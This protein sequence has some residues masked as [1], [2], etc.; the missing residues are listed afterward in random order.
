MCQFRYAVALAALLT[1]PAAAQTNW[2][3][4]STANGKIPLPPNSNQQTASLVAD[5]TGDGV[6]DFVMANRTTTPSLVFYTKTPNRAWQRYII[7]DQKTTIEAGGAATDMDADGDTDLIFAGDWQSNN[8]W[9]WENPGTAALK[10]TTPWKRHTIKAFGAKQ[11][12]DQIVGDFKRTGRPQVVSWNQGSKTLFIADVP[13][14]PKTG[15]WKLDTLFSG[16]AGEANSWYAEGLAAADIDG[17]GWLDLLGGNYWFRYVGKGKFKPVKIA[18]EGGRIG[19]GKFRPGRVQQVVISPGDGKGKLMY[20]EWTGQEGQ[21]S[22][23]NAALW[24]GRDLLGRTMIHGH[25]MEV[26]DLN[27]DG[28]LDFLTAEMAKWSEKETKPDNPAAEALIYYGDGR[29]NF[30]KEVFKTGWGFHEARVAD[31]DGDGDMDILSKPY[32]WETPRL[33]VW[34][35]NGS[36]KRVDLSKT[37]QRIGLELYSFRNELPKDVPGTLAKIKAMGI[38]EVE[39]AGYYDLTPEQFRAELDKAGLKATGALLGFDRF[40]T[41]VDGIIREAKILGIKAVGCAWIPHVRLFT[42]ADAEKGA[43]VF[44]AAGEKLRANGIRFYYHAHGYEF[45]PMMG[46]DGKPTGTLFDHMATLMKPGVAD[47]QIDVYWALHG[48]ERPEQLIRRYPNRIVGLHLKDMAWGQENGIYT[49][50][51]PIANDCIHGKG[52]QNF[53]AILAA[54]QQAGIQ[55]LYIEDENLNAINQVP[56]S[57]TYLRGLK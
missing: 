6:S 41:D 40:Q 4:E 16:S 43:A 46:A 34:L 19:V 45:R 33:D 37:Q 3:Y 25:T 57:L 5:L 47:F 39:V 7:D 30:R 22:V 42:K 26:A 12:H 27:N 50:G 53:K 38:N 51:A 32:N 8:I 2:V 18:E 15:P 48:G 54:A 55:H 11:H 23:D 20:Y 9:W 44:N 10:P 28:H 36:G 14:D 29:G 49:G 35:Q 1:L 13:N 31:I 17:D 21:D 52:Q 24:K 56:Q